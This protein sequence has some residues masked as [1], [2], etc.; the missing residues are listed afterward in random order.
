MGPEADARRKVIAFLTLAIALCI[1]PY[2]AIL[3][4]QSAELIPEVAIA[5]VMWA[6]GLAALITR[7]ATQRNLQGFGWRLTAPRYLFLCYLLP[8]AGCLVVYGLV[9]T[10]DL[11]T[12]KVSVARTA[13]FWPDVMQ[14]I[15]A[16]FAVEALLALGEELGWRGLLV[17]ELSKCMSFGRTAFISGAIWIVFHVPAML[18]SAYH[19]AAPLWFGLSMFTVSL[20]SISVILTWM[21]MRTGSVWTAVV[22]H[23]S[24][25]LFIQNLFDPMTI[26]H[27]L[28]EYV[29]TEFGVG[30]AFVYSVVAIVFWRRRSELTELAAGAGNSGPGTR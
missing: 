18:F 19:S 21:R 20:M 29:T 25:N 8:L 27:E 6:P 26:S 28:T 13:T 9:W 7:L 11:G 15:T 23:A 5:G 17:P 3:S 2:Y 1:P 14:A 24:H 22:L 4:A 30:L 10:T 16:G 12:F